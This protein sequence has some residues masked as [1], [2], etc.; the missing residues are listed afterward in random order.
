MLCDPYLLFF[1]VKFSVNSE[2][3][4]NLHVTFEAK[5]Q[6]LSLKCNGIFLGTYKKCLRLVPDNFCRQLKPLR[7]TL[8]EVTLLKR[9]I[10]DASHVS[11]ICLLQLSRQQ[12]LGFADGVFGTRQK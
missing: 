2:K 9:K 12:D 7:T 11:K 4:S 5:Q 1:F 6:N 10:G 3:I 8:L